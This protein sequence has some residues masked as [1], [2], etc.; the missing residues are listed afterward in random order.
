MS[1]H[2]LQ[3]AV[4]DYLDLTGWRYCAVPNG[5][6]R[7]AKVGQYLKDE[8]VQPGVPDI[9]IFEDWQ[10]GADSGHGVAI[11][12]K[13]GRNK[14][15]A[16]QEDWLRALDRRGWLVSVCRSMEQVLAVT[17]FITTKARIG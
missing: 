15:T 10:H 4:A 5:G 8:G 3:C 16:E 14:P 2:T 13:W 6:Q 11:E 12:L 9:L 1:E 7:S 17:K